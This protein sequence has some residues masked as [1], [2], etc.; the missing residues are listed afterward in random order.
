[1]SDEEMTLNDLLH[2]Q[3]DVENY[4]RLFYCILFRI[5]AEKPK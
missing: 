2:M 3:A 5:S 4:F 1:M